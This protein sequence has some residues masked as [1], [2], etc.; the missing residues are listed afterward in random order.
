MLQLTVRLDFVTDEQ[1]V[2]N[3]RY[4]TEQLKDWKQFDLNVNLLWFVILTSGV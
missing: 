1:K 3:Q 4:N 2:E